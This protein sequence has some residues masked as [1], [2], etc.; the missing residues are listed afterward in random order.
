MANLFSPRVLAILAVVVGALYL[1]TTLVPHHS[2]ASPFEKLY[3]HL[4]P[5]TLQPFGA[6]HGEHGEDA[7]GDGDHAEGEHAGE[8]HDAGHDEAAH[9]DASAHAGETH[10]DDGASSDVL[11]AVPLPGFLKAFE[12]H[13]Q[14]LAF[15]NLQLFQIAAILL[16][17]LCLS[18]VPRYL[19]TGQG[20]GVTKLFAGFVLWLRD[21][22]VYPVMGK[23]GGN[24][25][26]P[27]F[28]AIFFFILFMNVMGLLPYS[29]TP[30]A[31][32][33]V[34]FALA[35]LTLLCMLAFGIKEQGPV[36]YFKNLV[37]HVPIAIW[38]IMFVVELLGMFIKPA[39][40][41]IRLFAT[42]MGGHMAV[43]TF[44]GLILFLGSTMSVAV[45]YAVSPVAV[46]FA[47]FIMIIE[48]F[49]ALLQA[50]IFTQLSVIFIQSAIHPDH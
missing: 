44:I 50:F 4:M 18:G 6:G 26:L 24:R 2:A 14:G 9:E 42:M 12:N 16:I 17:F 43:L 20:D 36:G 31:S 40:L 45:G 46:G 13:P 33:F 47:V 19:R 27:Y 22:V 3:S 38:P 25:W 7:H 48:V 1:N 34:T 10:D 32:I 11:F 49:V 21:D 37:P 23:E 41:M 5:E 39:A 28:I 8:D 29:A 30:T 35:A 15:T